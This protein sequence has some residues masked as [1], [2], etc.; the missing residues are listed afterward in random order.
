LDPTITNHSTVKVSAM[1]KTPLILILIGALFLKEP[2][3]LIEFLSKVM[4]KLVAMKAHSLIVRCVKDHHR[5]FPKKE[6]EPK[7]KIKIFQ[8]S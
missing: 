2:Q 7:I 1:K 8:N 6:R 5:S 3:K 4:H